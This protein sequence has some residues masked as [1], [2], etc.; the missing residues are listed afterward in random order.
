LLLK[1]AWEDGV[2]STERNGNGEHPKRGTESR[3]SSLIRSSSINAATALFIYAMATL[4]AVGC[5]LILLYSSR[6][7]ASG[8]FLRILGVG[9]LAGGAAL[10]TGFLLG[11]I[12]A[13]PRVGDQKGKTKA[14]PP[15]GIHAEN[16][17]E[18]QDSVPFNANLVEISDWLTKIIVGVG[19]VELHSIPNALG[20]LSY[21]LAP[22]LL[23]APCSGGASCTEPLVT[24]QAVGLAILIFYFT[25]GFLLGCVWT[26]ISFKRILEAPKGQI[27]LLEEKTV[28]LEEK[29]GN[30]QRFQRA[31]VNVLNPRA[32]AVLSA[33]AS[34]SADQLDK[35]MA[36]INEALKSD[37]ENGLA[38]TTKARILKRQATQPGQPGRDKLLK[39]ALTYIDKAIN[40]QPDKGEPIY[41]KACY[42][43]LLDA[44]GLK[45]EILKNLESAFRLNPALRQTAKEDSDLSSMRQDID[46][47]NLTTK[48]DSPE[49]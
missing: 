8:Q 26:M 25:L 42:Q 18:Q 41:N 48:T 30:L 49:A 19:L 5:L 29:T 3:V 7:W 38:L 4:A 24:G 20:K 6:F 37:P 13:I 35:A 32:A 36:S 21:Y 43:A 45:G 28:L 22:G 15:E 1:F 27:E 34:I 33:E 9:M 23:P 16:S 11:F 2:L 12:F 31:A 40:L 46:F 44:K 10:L 39:E 14:V 17:G 47:I